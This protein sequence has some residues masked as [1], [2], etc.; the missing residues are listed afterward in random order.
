MGV[1]CDLPAEH[2]EEH[3]QRQL[4]DGSIAIWQLTEH[5]QVNRAN[6]RA[7]DWA[8]G[9]NANRYK[10]KRQ[11]R[12]LSSDHNATTPVLRASTC[13]ANEDEKLARKREDA[14]RGII[15]LLP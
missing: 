1:Y 9:I 2:L 6:Q 3:H 4:S 8:A 15:P 11:L 10:P 7:F 14:R 13:A 5:E 12:N